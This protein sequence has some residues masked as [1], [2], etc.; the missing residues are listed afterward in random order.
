MQ[1]GET[2]F[3][4]VMRDNGGAHRLYEQMGFRDQCETVV[5]VISLGSAS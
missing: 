3:L 2:L 4:H 1:R 5:R